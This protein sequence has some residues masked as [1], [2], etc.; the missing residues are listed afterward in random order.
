MRR[1]SFRQRLH[2]PCTILPTSGHERSQ[3]TCRLTHLRVLPAMRSR[4]H[5]ELLRRD[6]N[7]RAGIARWKSAPS[8]VTSIAS[9][10]ARGPIVRTAKAPAIRSK[11]RGTPAPEKWLRLRVILTSHRRRASS[12]ANSGR[13]RSAASPAG[14]GLK[15]AR[16]RAWID[17]HIAGASLSFHEHGRREDRCVVSHDSRS[18]VI[19]PTHL[20]AFGRH[21]H[22]CGLL[23]TNSKNES[24]RR[25][26]T[27]AACAEI[28]RFSGIVIT[29][30]FMRDTA[31]VWLFS[32][33]T[34]S[35]F[36]AASYN[37]ARLV[38]SSS[39]RLN[40]APSLSL[41]GAWLANSGS[42]GES[43][44]WSVDIVAVEPLPKYRLHLRFDDGTEG[45]SMFDQR[46]RSRESSNRSWMR[47]VSK[48]AS[49]RRDRYERL[50]E[51][52]R[53]RS[54]R[55]LRSD[56]GAGHLWDTGKHRS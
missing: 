17:V 22:C 31:Q 46:Y 55:T 26:D 14:P 42:F 34:G 48:S 30:N 47:R 44:H 38:W 21:A 45:E 32:R 23:W 5:S 25:S 43:R 18:V 56:L 37:R 36:T 15:S 11:F 52:H 4:Q 27:V 20:S 8:I 16:S 3:L 54:G 6:I 13:V 9:C 50:A 2:R 53:S 1:Q 49:E 28:R 10:R 12:S 51:W 35:Q 7:T 33:S 24:S 39:G 19:A 29:M 40:I 41:T